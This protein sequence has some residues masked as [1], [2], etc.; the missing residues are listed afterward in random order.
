MEPSKLTN[1]SQR[2]NEAVAVA[3]LFARLAKFK[4]QISSTLDR[5][6]VMWMGRP[7]HRLVT[8]TSLPP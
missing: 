1:L 8:P 3:F 7:G 4:T 2:N 5:P 6:L